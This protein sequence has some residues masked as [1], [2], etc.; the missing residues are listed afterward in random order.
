[1]PEST[2]VKMA[3]KPAMSPVLLTDSQTH[4]PWAGNVKEIITW[5]KM[6]K[7]G[8]VVMVCWPWSSPGVAHHLSGLSWKYSLSLSIASFTRSLF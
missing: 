6:A 7:P 5:C 2:S 1:M 3:L 8:A 4:L